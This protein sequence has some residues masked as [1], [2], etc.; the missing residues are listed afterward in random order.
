MGKVPTECRIQQ[1]CKL[2]M[3]KEQVCRKLLHHCK[4]NSITFKYEIKDL[5]DVPDVGYQQTLMYGR[6]SKA[7]G[8]VAKEEARKQKIIERERHKEMLRRRNSLTGS[9]DSSWKRNPAYLQFKD[10]ISYIWGLT[11]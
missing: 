10:G 11:G 6:Y 1:Y 4:Y 2:S 5:G 8:E 3:M 7:L 9:R